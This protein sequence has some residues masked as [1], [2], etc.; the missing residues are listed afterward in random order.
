MDRKKKSKKEGMSREVLLLRLSYLIHVYP[1]NEK[2]KQ[3]HR[4]LQEFQ[5]PFYSVGFLKQLVEKLVNDRS[6]FQVLLSINSKEDLEKKCS[7]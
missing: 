4:N 7:S 5:R 6:V 3:L 1:Q 2:L